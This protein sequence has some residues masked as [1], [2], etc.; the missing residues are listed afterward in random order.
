MEG[1]S[2]RRQRPSCPLLTP[3]LPAP[4]FPSILSVL[5][6]SSM[7]RRH[8]VRTAAA[9]AVA[10]LIV[11]RHVL[12][13]VGFQSPSDTL[14]IAAIGA[15]GMGASNMAA[16]TDQHIVALA[17]VDFDYVDRSVEGRLRTRAGLV[18][19]EYAALQ[20]AYAEANRYADFREMLDAEADLDAVVV[21]TPDHTHAIAA[22]DAMRRGLHVYVQ[23]PLT[24]SVEEARALKAAAAA[25][26]DLVTQMG[27]QGHSGDDGRRL[28]ELVRSGLL[29]EI[30]EVQAWT[31]RPAGWWPQGVPMPEP[32]P[33][34]QNVAW[35][36]WL[37][38]A[39]DRPYLP[40]VHP[41]AW[42][43]YVDFGVGALGDMGAHILDFPVWA[44][45][46]G[47]P[48]RI[49]TRHTPWG[50][51]RDDPATYP[52]GSV[53]TYSFARAGSDPLTLTWFD[54]G[55]MPPTP[56]GA[57]EGFA[58]N[59][60]G[61][62]IFVGERGVLVYDTYGRNPRLLP[63]S[64]ADEAAAV[65]TSLPRIEGGMGGH[66][67]NWVRAIRGEE[68]ISSPFSYAADLTETMLLGIVAMH[69]AKPIAYDAATMSIPNAPEAERHLRRTYR[70]GWA[71]PTL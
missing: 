35:N 47:Q 33:K 46:L 14:R 58:L 60:D 51:E 37:G 31:D 32:A 5:S 22:L 7:D 3:A 59:T 44:L 56:A 29:G 69:A 64:L 55:L 66:E 65:P 48:T 13:G 26:P 16:L 61:G 52:L 36:L 45:D 12:G 18:R 41:F 20:D 57:P 54:G 49:Q 63:E 10:P 34:P 23:K 62:G 68:P 27:N 30:R 38:P 9:A 1:T 28:V 8:F 2:L 15:G 71:L 21:A 25:R 40:D 42:R 67:Q 11:P 50:G 17:D 39:E 70:D 43:G 19:P 6:V 24:Y 53:T 4:V